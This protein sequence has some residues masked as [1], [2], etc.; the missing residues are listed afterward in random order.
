MLSQFYPPVIGGEERHVRS[1]G[2][3]LAARGHN[4]AVATQ[5]YPGQL[6]TEDDLG[7]AV[8]RIRGT[9]QRSARLFT[10]ASRRHAPP[11]PDPE[12][13]LGLS[14]ILREFRPDVVHAHNWIVHSFAPLK[15]RAG[16]PVVLTLHDYGM[17]CAKK[18]LMR[19]EEVCSGPGLVKCLDCA[20]GHYGAL[21]GGVTTLSNWMMNGFSPV[22]KVL[23][24]SSAVAEGNGLAARGIPFEVVPNFIPDDA[25]LADGAVDP[26][27]EQLPEQLFLL[28]VGDLRRQKGIHVVLDA[29]ARLPDR[30]PLVL[31]G[32]PCPDTPAELPDGARILTNWPH[33]SVMRA[34]HR[35]AVALAPSI[36]PEPCATVVL[37]AMACGKPVI[38]SRM[39]GMPDM[40]LD[41]ETGWLV[42]PNDPADLARALSRLLQNPDEARRM[43]E[44]G[45]RH[46]AAFEARTVVPRI[47]NV[48]LSLLQR[49]AA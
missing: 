21:K 49:R 3:A 9:M 41:G 33:A 12:F 42:K 2:A 8:H 16:A 7:V 48:Y 36:W 29:Y 30:P 24:V 39:G 23:T 38:A 45:R 13:T 46:V 14:R 20:R 32:R 17:V 28:F 27:L 11:F 35:A 4:V 22:D 34:W 40:V 5:W 15:H 6:E 37:E 43:G 19:G 26:L 25:G 31:I 10:D 18:N 47:E 1:L 44:A